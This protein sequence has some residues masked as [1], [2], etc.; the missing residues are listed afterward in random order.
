M[1]FRTPSSVLFLAAGLAI[2][3]SAFGQAAAPSTPDPQKAAAPVVKGP[4]SAQ[5][6]ESARAQAYYHAA[7]A[8]MYEEMVTSYGQPEYATQAIEEYKLALGFDPQN[9]ELNTGLAALYL[10]VGRVRD[11]VVEAQALVKRDP[12]NLEAHKLLGRVYLRSLGDMQ[13]GTQSDEVLKLAIA[14][15]E[16]ISRLEPKSVEDHLL[17]GQLYT[18]DKQPAKGKAEFEA[19]RNLD[20]GSED[21]VLNLARL[22]G[23]QGETKQSIKVL[24]SVP[25]S[26]RS[27]KIE[28]ALASSYDE[29]RDTQD[30][31]AAYKS[32]LAAQ[33]DNADAARALARDYMLNGDNAGAM[34]I[35]KKM[36]QADP[37][38]AFALVRLADLERRTG[39]YTGAL[40]SL[41]KAQAFVK[42]S[43][44]LA[45]ELQF[46]RALVE[47]TLNHY[48]EAEAILEKLEAASFHGDNHYTDEE[49]NNRSVFLD[50][51]ANVYREQG[52][53]AQ[54]VETYRKMVDLGGEYVARGYQFMIDT[55]RDAHDFPKAL[56]AAQEAAKQQ[57]N[58]RDLKLILAAQLCD[59]G[60]TEEGLKL[61]AAQLN[62]TAADRDVYLDIAQMQQRLKNYSQASDA[63]DKAEKLAAK[64]DD[65]IFI[66]FERASLLQSEKHYDEAEESY[67]KVLVIDPNNAMALNDLGFMQVDRGVKLED[68][69]K[70][71]KKAV[72]LDPQNGAYLDSLGW[73]YFKLGQYELAEQNLRNAVDRS[74]SD[75]SLHDH[76]GQLYEKMGRLKLAS[77][78]WDKALK[79]YASSSPADVDPA[80]KT[81]VEKHL[82]MAR[83]KLARENGAAVK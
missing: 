34:A 61:A 71:I 38:D 39:D 20:P 66:Y 31:I 64:P 19:A 11:A 74:P 82:E 54:A 67:R 65:R 46:N 52:K 10:K 75:P 7:L 45:N 6:S 69:L 57:P 63:I 49:R 18:L 41:D 48:D 12:N 16:T 79:L 9:S 56:E 44:S 70:M 4:A 22:Y 5:V 2:A 17:L 60:K 53:T 36:S 26:Q 32:L 14:E 29:E 51:L 37:T 80:D 55:Y 3:P 35:Y 76:L 40:A 78:Q 13:E 73:A 30:A 24:E 43:P 25:E 77:E 8:D 81:R 47:D 33:P 1:R 27:E 58:N 28:F 50:R 42:D 59:N 21:A 72:E 62:N 15:Y 83:V 68:S 23:E